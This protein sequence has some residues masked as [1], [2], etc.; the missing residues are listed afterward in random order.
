L[1]YVFGTEEIALNVSRVLLSALLVVSLNTGLELKAQSAVGISVA[2]PPYGFNVIPGSTRRLFATVTNGATNQVTWAVKTGTGTLSGN[3]GSWVD[4]VAPATGTS[5]AYAGTSA[6]YSVTSATTFTVEATSVDDP[7]KKADV[8]VNVCNPAVQVSVVP[9]YRTLYANQPADIQSF[10]LGA[11][12]Q[13]V[14]WAISVQPLGGDGKLGDT[15]SRDTVFS[16]T[17]PGRYTLTATSQADPRKSS[18][19][20]MFVTGNKLPY[21]T[22]KNLT[23]PVDCT[24]DP[25]MVGHVYEVGPSQTYKTLASVPFPT[26]IP[27]STVR[28]HN[29]DTS[30]TNPTQYHEYVQISQ[31]ATATQPFR[32]CGVPDAYGNEPIMDGANATGRSDTSI[33][34]AGYGLVTLHNP[35]YWNY[36]PAYSSAAYISVEG[37]HLRNAKTGFNY[38]APDGSAAQWGDASAALRVNQGINTAFVGNDIDNCGDGVFTA[39]NGNGGWGS[40]DMNVL[41][42]GNRIHGNGAIGSYLSHQ[43]YLQAWGEVVQFNRI[44]NYQVGAYG[45][46]LKSRGIQS[47]IRYNYLGDGA[48]REMDLVD[49]QDAPMYMSFN[50]FL[51]GGANSYH[52]LDP[53]D[54]YPADLIAAEQEAWNWHFVYGNI[55]QNS[56]ASVP[57]HFSYD[58]DGGELSRKGNLYWYNNTFYETLCANCSG[59]IWALFDTTAGG[60]SYYPQTEFQTIQAYNNIVWMDDPTRPVFEW[61]NYTTFIGVAGKN[62]LPN[63]WGNNNQAGGS[64]TGWNTSPNSDAYQNATTMAAHLTGFNSTNLMTAGSIPFSATTWALNADVAGDLVV[65]SAVCE[66][67]TRFAYLPSLSYAVPRLKAPN[68]G[69]TDTSQEMAAAM[70]TI[71]GASRNNTRNSNC[72]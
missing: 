36:W 32:M 44:E 67:P 26:M 27:G 52:A 12:D 70:T 41:W 65:P 48:A 59:Q 64:G 25:A 69:A 19:A 39:W 4:V 23:E 54:N 29:E 8:I 35:N 15:T 71:V 42:E 28:L 18:T 7:T 47:V 3:T 13:N 62:L 17:V 37:I 60:G 2:Q 43:M 38:T 16:A 24:V 57:I 9:F 51:S 34:A 58:H 30:G 63:S 21:Q 49:V 66:M 22:T 1:H 20:I 40:E 11:V 61:N 33:Y 31:A 10:I 53:L 14:H 56:T 46:N 50:G 5:C 72:Q 6:N 55:Y 68:V 45:S